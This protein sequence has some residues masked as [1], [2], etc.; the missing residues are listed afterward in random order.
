MCIHYRGECNQLTDTVWVLCCKAFLWLSFKNC[1]V[2]YKLQ[3]GRLGGGGGSEHII[4]RNPA[5]TALKGEMFI[6]GGESCSPNAL[7]FCVET[8]VVLF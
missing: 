5:D 1:V 3:E 6:E 2:K 4:G 8:E 7:L